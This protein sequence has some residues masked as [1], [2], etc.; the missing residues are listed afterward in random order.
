MNEGAVNI[1]SRIYFLGTLK[2]RPLQTEAI[3][4]MDTSKLN[5]NLKV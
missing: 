2:I 4:I 3:H 5:Y 1:V